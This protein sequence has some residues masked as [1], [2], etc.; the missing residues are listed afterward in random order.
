MEWFPNIAKFRDY[1][2]LMLDEIRNCIYGDLS[3]LTDGGSVC[4]FPDVLHHFGDLYKFP[5]C[6]EP[7]G[8]MLAMVIPG[9]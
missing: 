9:W 8:N 4:S 7:H 2:H 1:S 6:K 5:A 3:Y